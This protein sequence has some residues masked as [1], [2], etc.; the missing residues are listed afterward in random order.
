MHTQILLHTGTTGSNN[1]A[2]TVLGVSGEELKQKP[3]YW[4]VDYGAK[5]G[6]TT[7]IEVLPLHCDPQHLHSVLTG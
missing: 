3:R 1:S 4:F 5:G 7:K 6:D 2:W